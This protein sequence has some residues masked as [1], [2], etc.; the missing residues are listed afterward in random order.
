[1]NVLFAHRIFALFLLMQFY[2]SKLTYFQK[3]CIKKGFFLQFLNFQ[4]G[5]GLI[6]HLNKSY[7]L[8]EL[9]GERE[10]FGSRTTV[11]SPSSPDQTD[12]ISFGNLS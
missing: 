4:S 7:S 8:T 3:I 10:N 1:M 2:R 6:Q 5:G 9:D 12:K 11:S